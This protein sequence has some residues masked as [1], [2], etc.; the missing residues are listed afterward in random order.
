MWIR[1]LMGRLGQGMLPLLRKAAIAWYRRGP[2][3]GAS[4][5]R[6][7]AQTPERLQQIKPEAFVGR[8]VPQERH[9]TF[10]YVPGFFRVLPAGEFET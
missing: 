3:I 8:V 7:Q 1:R 10:L 6:P 5:F 9:V 4:G 2:A